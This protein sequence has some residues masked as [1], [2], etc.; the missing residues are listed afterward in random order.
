M[1]EKHKNTKLLFFSHT[2]N[3]QILYGIRASMADATAPLNQSLLPSSTPN[4]IIP[5]QFPIS[6]KLN[7]SNFL[8]WKSQIEPIVH[9][10]KLTNFLEDAPPARQIQTDAGTTVLNPAFSNWECQDQ[11]LL[12]WIRSS[13]TETI[14]AQVSSCKTSNELWVSLKQSFSATSRARLT[15]L[16][17]QLHSAVKGSSSCADYLH[18]M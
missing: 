9:G 4:A 3:L 10:F 17:R 1:N 16:R 2:N 5:L 14:L 8:T 6:T 13:L 12:G 11:L 18:K 7:H 15:D